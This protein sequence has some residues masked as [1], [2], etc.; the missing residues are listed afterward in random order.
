MKFL[1]N[2]KK[3]GLALRESV[4]AGAFYTAPSR[5]PAAFDCSRRNLSSRRGF[6]RCR[7][8]SRIAFSA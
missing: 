1:F 3:N 8:S 5:L 4:S 6:T 2:Y 7:E